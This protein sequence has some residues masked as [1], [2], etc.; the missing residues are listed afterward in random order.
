MLCQLSYWPNIFFFDAV[1]KLTTSYLHFN[2][3]SG[4]VW[5][6]SDQG[7]KNKLTSVSAFSPTMDWSQPGV[8]WANIFYSIILATTPAPTVLPPSRI[9]KRKPSCIAIGA[10]KVTDI[11]TLSPGITISTPSGNSIAPVISVVLK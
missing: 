4:C 11:C 9:A 6:D 3:D 8:S 5:L 1:R 2:I 10:I 7:G